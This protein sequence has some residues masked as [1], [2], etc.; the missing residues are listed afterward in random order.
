MY[1]SKRKD[2]S[3]AALNVKML[4]TIYWIYCNSLKSDILHDVVFL[5]VKIETGRH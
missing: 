4:A 2:S 5:V 3:S 1:K